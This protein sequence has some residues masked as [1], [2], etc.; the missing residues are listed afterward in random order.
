M[1]LTQKVIN[2]WILVSTS[3]RKGTTMIKKLL[4]VIVCLCAICCMLSSCMQRSESTDHP[5]DPENSEKINAVGGSSACE[6]H[7]E[8]YHR[9][10]IGLTKLVD[11]NDITNWSNE[12]VKT[13]KSVETDCTEYGIRNNRQS[14]Y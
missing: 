13:R 8:Q 4:S 14:I 6:V 11:S 9:L 1:H 3:I 12:V 2:T 10:S 5:S 7:Y